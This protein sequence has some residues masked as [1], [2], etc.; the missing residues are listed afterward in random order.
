MKFLSF[1][2]VQSNTS[3]K[4]KRYK[5]PNEGTHMSYKVSSLVMTHI[6]VKNESWWLAQGIQETLY[7][8]INN[9]RFVC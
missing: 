9:N 6:S 5:L 3:F 1:D 7:E 2:D 4:Y 8:N